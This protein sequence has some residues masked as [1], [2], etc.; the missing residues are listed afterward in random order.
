MEVNLLKI[1]KLKYMS[2]KMSADNADSLLNLFPHSEIF[3]LG[4]SKRN[5]DCAD[6][7]VEP[8][9][10][11]K[12]EYMSRKRSADNADSLSNLF[13]HSETFKLGSSKRNADSADS[14]VEPFQN[15]EIGVYV[16]KNERR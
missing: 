16:P 13:P 2:R 11:S 8:S 9:Q 7:E 15:F 1:L 6:S 14:E 5:A 4:P 3:K 10:K 12:L